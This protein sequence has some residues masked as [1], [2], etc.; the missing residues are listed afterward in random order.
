MFNQRKVKLDL[1][2]FGWVRAE[3]GVLD[4]DNFDSTKNTMQCFTISF[5]GSF[6]EHYVGNFYTTFDHLCSN[7][8]ITFVDLLSTF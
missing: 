3:L 5:H 7:F 1:L 4:Q 6:Y 8:D 2:E